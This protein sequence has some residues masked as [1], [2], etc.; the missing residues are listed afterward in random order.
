MLDF[1][2]QHDVIHLMPMDGISLHAA[3]GEEPHAAPA[4]SHFDAV[5]GHT[6]DESA[7]AAEIKHQR[8]EDGSALGA[9]GAGRGRAKAIW[10]MTVGQASL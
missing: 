7:G 3:R 6:A 5:H 8:I 10:P 2:L 4:R 1:G 9:G